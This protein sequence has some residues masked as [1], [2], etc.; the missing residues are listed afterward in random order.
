VHWLYYHI[1]LVEAP[2]P[3]EPN[4]SGLFASRACF[5]HAARS[6]LESTFPI[7]I[8]EDYKRYRLI[9]VRV[10]LGAEVRGE[11]ENGDYEW[12]DNQKGVVKVGG[13]YT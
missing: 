6:E 11:A 13:R 1:D 9:I 5:R 3:Y 7:Y 12:T 4:L 2:G 10:C 8:A